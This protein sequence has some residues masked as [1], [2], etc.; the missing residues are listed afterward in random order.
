MTLPNAILFGTV[1][2][3]SSSLYKYIKQHPEI[4]ASEIKEPNFFAFMGHKP[5]FK[6]PDDEVINT[7]SITD[8]A[9][10]EALFAG[11]TIEKAICEA[12]VVYIYNPDAACRMKQTIPNV[13][14]FALL[15][16]PA[17]RAF[18]SY[19]H[20]QRDGRETAESFSAALSEEPARIAANWGH[21]FHYRQMGYYYEQLKR[22]YDLFSKEQIAV[23]KYEDFARD[24]LPIIKNIF[25]FLE[26][27]DTYSPDTTRR[28]NISG[29]PKSKLLQRWLTR[30]SRFKNFFKPL[31]PSR[32]RNDLVMSNLK[33]F[34]MN[35]EKPMLNQELRRELLEGYADDINRLQDLINLDLSSWYA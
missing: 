3:G 34:N 22:Y 7:R 8:L 28:Y 11:A 16:N 35:T 10:Y 5:E 25:Q 13:K 14:L 26:V 12:S 15:R 18:S 6:G 19:L 4:Y 33:R 29:K 2:S 1:K 27:D 20:A 24:P 23:F 21:L 30:P 32:V 31:I 9:D 17:D